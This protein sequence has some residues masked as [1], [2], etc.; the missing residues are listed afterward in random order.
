MRWYENNHE[1]IIPDNALL[2][3]YATLYQHA[4]TGHIPYRGGYFF[5]SACAC[6]HTPKNGVLWVW[7]VTWVPRFRVQYVSVSS[8]LWFVA[9]R[10][11]YCSRPL[12]VGECSAFLASGSDPN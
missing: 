12:L 10:Q 11:A 5:N 1:D 2:A 8:R 6:V 4:P 7:H 3:T 9:A